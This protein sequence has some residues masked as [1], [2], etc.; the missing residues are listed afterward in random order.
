MESLTKIC[1]EEKN[2]T[3]VEHKKYF[4][5]EEFFLEEPRKQHPG[6]NKTYMS[7]SVPVPVPT[8]CTFKCIPL[9]D[10]ADYLE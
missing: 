10:D 8:F 2:N 9:I 6:E 1:E 7:P 4:T 5:F 3:L